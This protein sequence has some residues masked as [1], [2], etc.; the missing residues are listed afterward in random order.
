MKIVSIDVGIA[1]LAICL[2]SF[3]KQQQLPRIDFWNVLDLTETEV[4]ATPPRTCGIQLKKSQKI[5]GKRAYFELDNVDYCRLHLGSSKDA[6]NAKPI[7][8]KK[9][10]KTKSLSKSELCDRM[11][12][13][14][15]KL[16]ENVGVFNVD[17][18]IIEL[19]P[20]K[21]QRMKAFSEMIFTYFSIRKRD[22]TNIKAVKFINAKH[23]LSLYDGPAIPC[24]LRDKYARRKF[25][26]IQ[27]CRYFLEKMTTQEAAADTTAAQYLD[28]FLKSSKR[29]D[30]ADCYLQGLYYLKR[31]A[32]A[33]NLELNLK[34]ENEEQDEHDDV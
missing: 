6:T 10:R 34:E 19:Q 5:C 26:G 27:H 31:Y 3:E 8:K 25:Y 29:D 28:F 32:G 24:K 12:D 1:N 15:D 23:K 22:H 9:K 17:Y 11:V 13:R 14:I 33:L 21:N 4:A 18:V 7:Q 30:L 2:L 16:S 20:G